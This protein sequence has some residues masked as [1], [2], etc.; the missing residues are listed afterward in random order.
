MGLFVFWENSK[1]RCAFYWFDWKVIFLYFWE[2]TGLSRQAQHSLYPHRVY[3]N[4]L[5][6]SSVGVPSAGRASSSLTGRRVPD[7]YIIENRPEKNI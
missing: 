3:R 2:R 1:L 5:A 7:T 4:A 6:A